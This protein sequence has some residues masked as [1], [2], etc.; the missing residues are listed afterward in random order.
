M[1]LHWSSRRNISP[2]WLIK[3]NI[4]AL[5]SVHERKIWKSQ[6]L[7][8]PAT[9]QDPSDAMVTERIGT[10][11]AGAYL[12]LERKIQRIITEFLT[13]SNMQ[14]FS[15]RSHCFMLPAWSHDIN[16]PWLGWIQT[17]FTSYAQMRIGYQWEVWDE[18]YLVH[19]CR[20]SGALVLYCRV[21]YP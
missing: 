12:N 20:N 7:L 4:C 5:R 13:K 10:S 1:Y 6:T 3:R 16:S 18:E 11:P 9:K 15:D 8:F 14:T 2:D 17:S 19:H 21:N